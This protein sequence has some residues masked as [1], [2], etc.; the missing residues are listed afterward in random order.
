MSL[1]NDYAFLKF[2]FT[3]RTNKLAST[4][5]CDIAA[6]SYRSNYTD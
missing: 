1:S 4:A 6:F 2:N 5:A 3:F